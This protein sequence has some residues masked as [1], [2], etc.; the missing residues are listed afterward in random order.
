MFRKKIH[1]I[2]SRLADIRPEE[3]PTSLLMFIYFFLIT[4][5]AWIIKP[6]KISLFLEKL[7]IER[8]PYAYLLT[9]ALI[10]FVVTLNSRLLRTMKR[11]LYISLSLIFFISNLLLFWLLFR[12]QWQ[13]ISLIYWFWAEI[14]TITSVTQFW[15]LVNDIYTPRQAKRLIGFL[16][17]GGLLG[18]VAG[19]LLASRLAE[20]VR[21]ENLLLI[22][23]FMLSICVVIV[24][25]VPRFIKREKR[26]EV[27]STIETKKPKIGYRKSFR[28]LRKNRHLI[29]LSGIMISA[30]LVTTLVDFQF[31]SLIEDHFTVNGSGEGF[32]RK[33]AMT[34]FLGT[35]FTVLLIFSSLLHILLTSRILKNFGI[36]IALLIAPFFLLIGS[37]AIFFIPVISLISIIVELKS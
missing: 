12:L 17:S 4:S 20:I 28:L 33:D 34:S 8:L 27:E 21:T 26:E 16:V 10:G 24:N 22:C 15:I 37:I 36:R 5:S 2:L 35:F 7:S 31:N 18:G 3:T 6:V 1:K 30:I 11:E 23:P 19:A 25:L 32:I 29:L 13:W 9:A 14:F